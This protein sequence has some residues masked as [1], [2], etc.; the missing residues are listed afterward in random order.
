MKIAHWS[1]L[2]KEMAARRQRISQ[3]LRGL[4]GPHFIEEVR[5]EPALTPDGVPAMKD[6]EPVMIYR[7]VKISTERG[8]LLTALM[9]A[10][11]AR[12]NILRTVGR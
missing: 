1:R 11:T 9:D 6:G 10:E 12:G 2:R 8:R 4:D 3:K 7:A 5:A